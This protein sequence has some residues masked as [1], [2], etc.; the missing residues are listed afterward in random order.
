[1]ENLSK[2]KLALIAVC[3]W[4]ISSVIDPALGVFGLIAGIVLFWYGS[5]KGSVKNKAL[6]DQQ[7]KDEARNLVEKIKLEKKLEP[8]STSLLLEK[9]EYAFLKENTVLMES[10]SIR[11]SVGLGI[12]FRVM[13]GVHVGGYKG[14]S[15][16]NQELRSVESG[17]LIITNKK[18]VFRGTMENRVIPLSKIIEIKMHSDAIEIATTG[19]QKSSIFTVANPYIWNVNLFILSKVENP[20]DFS[21]IKNIDIAIS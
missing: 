8:I 14:Q 3:I 21:G 16:S 13:K 10:K 6:V 15:E 4:L 2:T 1:M 20:L 18:L 5:K 9:D 12:G 11:N 17:D 19:R 7:Q